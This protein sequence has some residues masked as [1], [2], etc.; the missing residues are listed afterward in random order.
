MCGTLW[1]SCSTTSL[2]ISIEGKTPD[3][4]AIRSSSP[5]IDLSQ[6]GNAT[7]FAAPTLLCADSKVGVVSIRTTSSLESIKGL[8]HLTRSSSVKESLNR[9]GE[10]GRGLTD[11]DRD[12]SE[13]LV[14]K[15]SE[16]RV[17]VKDFNFFGW[18][19]LLWGGIET[20]GC[21]EGRRG[22]SEGLV[23]EASEAGVGERDFDFFGSEDFLWGGR[24]TGG[25]GGGQLEFKGAGGG[26]GGGILSCKL[27]S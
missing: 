26:G 9:S 21:G 23:V 13:G 1:L 19:D 14:V 25:C 24:E 2:F 6:G 18:V 27:F 15:A 11:E 10:W 8:R 16:V 12:D 17:G 3:S 4:I 7:S 22:G 5:P 20:G